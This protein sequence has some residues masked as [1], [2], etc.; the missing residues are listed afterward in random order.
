MREREVATCGEILSIA[1]DLGWVEDLVEE[2]LAGETEPSGAN[3]T[4]SVHV[5]SARDAFDV[6]GWE[7]LTRSAWARGGN[8]VIEDAC[9]SGFDLC[10]RGDVDRIEF[11]VRWRPRLRGHAAATLLRTR[12]ILLTR[13]VLLQYPALWR[14]TIR[15]RAP[16]H[17]VVCTAGQA[18]PM[19]AGPAG[20]GKSTL[21]QKELAAGGRAISDNVCVSDGATAWGLVEPLRVEGAE[22][23]AVTHGRRETTMTR[24]EESLTPDLLVALR[25]DDLDSPTVRTCGAATTT[26]SLVAGTYMAGELRRFWGFAATLAAGTGLG[27][28]HPPVDSIAAA[29]AS[30]LP[31]VEIVLPRQPGVRLADLLNRAE[32]TA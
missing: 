13:A 23:R 22:G 8:V 15:G 11:V 21:L 17:A 24:R 16:L 3:P 20:V 25:R 26:R 12:F 27:P 28:A 6:V 2:A 7:P 10:L 1:C 30:R 5:E 32:V 18:T 14:A 29:L 19:L 31:A 9:S 4:L